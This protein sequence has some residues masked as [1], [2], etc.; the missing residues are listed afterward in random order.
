MCICVCIYIYVCRSL[1]VFSRVR[2]Q[3]FTSV[4][5]RRLR[6]S[7]GTVGQSSS[8]R[9]PAPHLGNVTSCTSQNIGVRVA[10]PCRRLL[11]EGES[12]DNHSRWIVF[13]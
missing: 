9:V 13:G 2:A 6:L 4:L 8:N 10:P 12:V 7:T 5:L 11:T 3:C 1:L